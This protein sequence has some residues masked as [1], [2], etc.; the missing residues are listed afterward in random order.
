MHHREE[1]IERIFR[2]ETVSL[3]SAQQVAMALGKTVGQ[4]FEVEIDRRPMTKK[5]DARVQSVHS[6]SPELRQ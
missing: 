3:D 6:V 2:G 1:T 4:M 5:D